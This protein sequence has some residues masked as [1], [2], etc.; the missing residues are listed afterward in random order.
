MNRILVVL[1]LVGFF[2][3]PVSTQAQTSDLSPGCQAAANGE[4]DV[5]FVPGRDYKSYNDNNGGIR[6]FAGEAVILTIEDL[7]NDP[8]IDHDGYLVFTKYVDPKIGPPVVLYTSPGILSNVAPLSLVVHSI[9][10]DDWYGFE[11][12]YFR[13]P[14]A[15][16]YI[17]YLSITV[18]CEARQEQLIRT[19]V[20]SVCEGDNWRNLGFANKG[21]CIRDIVNH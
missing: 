8:E 6:F 5:M 2:I 16:P 7:D 17:G 18:T 20:Q 3:T 19:Q 13:R 14:P 4:L 12:Q 15:S 10:A 21:A 9:T 11:W 1:I